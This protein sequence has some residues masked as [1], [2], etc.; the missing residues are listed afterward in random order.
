M[1]PIRTERSN[2]VFRGPTPNIGDAY[3]EISDSR[4][5]GR[6]Y[7]DTKLV[8]GLSPQE[9]AAIASGA[10]VELVIVGAWPIPPVSLNI[11]DEHVLDPDPEFK[12]IKL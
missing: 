1:H 6:P 11:N 5:W 12:G 3:C 8:W 2:F 4:E 10:N 9:R 7:R